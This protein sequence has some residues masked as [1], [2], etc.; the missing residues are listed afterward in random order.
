MHVR[1]LARLGKDVYRALGGIVLGKHIG[2]GMVPV[3]TS[4]TEGPPNA[5]G[6]KRSTQKGFASIV[7]NNQP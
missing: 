3:S 4:Q 1:K 2:L 5:Q 6:I 7:G